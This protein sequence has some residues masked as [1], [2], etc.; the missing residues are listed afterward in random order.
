MSIELCTARKIKTLTDL[1]FEEPAAIESFSNCAY[2]EMLSDGMHVSRNEHEGETR[3]EETL[4]NLEN[5]TNTGHTIFAFDRDSASQARVAKVHTTIL[6]LRKAGWPPAF[7]FIYDEAWALVDDL[8]AAAV[9][10]LGDD[11]VMEP[12]LNCW[13]LSRSDAQGEIYVGM[14]FGAPHRDLRYDNCHNEETDA[15][16]ALSTWMPVNPSGATEANGCMRVIAIEDD[17]FYYCPDHPHHHDQATALA[18]DDDLVAHTTALAAAAGDVCC[19]VPCVVHWG[20]AFCDDALGG[21]GGAEP[22]ASIAAT[23]RRRDAPR[24]VFGSLAAPG[25]IAAE[26]DCDTDE[27]E[28]ISGPQP[29]TRAGARAV[30]LRTRLAYVAKALLAYSHWYPGFPGLEAA[31]LEA[32]SSRIGVFG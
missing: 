19:W 25:I 14:A 5:L 16:R 27:E 2:W 22:R 7:I 17:A 18:F 12:D 29:L 8:F 3:I 4:A 32:G 28:P 23:L 21:C 13:C 30:P 11:C 10:E 26:P 1:Y 15:P 20:G 9:P 31:R 6:A 24:S